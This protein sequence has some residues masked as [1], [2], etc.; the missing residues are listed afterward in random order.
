[1]LLYTGVRPAELVN[2]DVR[3]VLLDA[4]PPQI[5]IRGAVHH[6][7]RKRATL[8]TQAAERE[9]PLTMSRGSG[10]ATDLRRW[11]ASERPRDA[12][13]TSLFCSVRRGPDGRRLPLS[14]DALESVL[15]RLQRATGI[16]C[17]AYRFRHT[18]ATWLVDAGMHEQHV[19]QIMGWDDAS[20]VR[21]YFRG[22]RNPAILEA[23]AGIMS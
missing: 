20:M 10:I 22:N 7:S 16:H 9:V 8:K 19:M 14:V 5:L 6:R 11:L 4:R 2:L 23:A 1:M 21:R 17:N 18:C 12:G 3:S 15:E 13:G